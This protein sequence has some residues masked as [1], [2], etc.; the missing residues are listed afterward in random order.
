MKIAYPLLAALLVSAASAAEPLKLEPLPE[1]P[2]PP[3]VTNGEAIKPEV[4]VKTDGDNKVEEYRVNGQL[5][6]IKVTPPTGVA[7]YMVDAKG[8]GEFSRYDPGDRTISVPQWVLFT[9]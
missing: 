8:T 9:W 5:Y 1:I 7:Y 6:M 3:A 2:P 4:T